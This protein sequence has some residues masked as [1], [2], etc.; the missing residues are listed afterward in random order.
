MRDTGAAPT[1]VPA[2]QV[3]YHSY[4]LAREAD[5]DGPMGGYTRLLTMGHADN[6]A[7]LVPTVVVDGL[8]G[9]IDPELA[10]P[11]LRRCEP[12]C[13]WCCTP[14]RLAPG[15]AG[16]GRSSC[17]SGRAVSGHGRYRAY[18]QRLANRCWPRYRLDT[19]RAWALSQWLVR[20]HVPEEFVFIVDT[21]HIFLRQPPLPET[22]LTI[23]VWPLRHLD[24]RDAA[25]M[26]HCTNPEYNP[27]GIKPES[28][29][30]VRATCTGARATLCRVKLERDS[31]C[32][33]AELPPSPQG[34]HARTAAGVHR[35]PQQ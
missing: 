35:R 24:C 13:R 30:R 25:V 18:Y 23:D 6:V 31:T 5:P 9:S 19:R 20:V 1:T 22:P 10:Y 3:S 16:L 21:D 33:A 28:I 8:P 7:H 11:H 32:C 4:R 14:C 15:S 2:L 34:Q 12:W 26:S 27:R 17:P 29:P